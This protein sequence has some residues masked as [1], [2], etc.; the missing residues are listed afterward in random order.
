M[1]KINQEMAQ[2]GLLSKRRDSRPAEKIARKLHEAGAKQDA[3]KAMVDEV[4]RAKIRKLTKYYM[5]LSSLYQQ[6]LA[7]LRD[8]MAQSQP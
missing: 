4:E 2:H 6:S 7:R 8:P 1:D 3:S 5:A